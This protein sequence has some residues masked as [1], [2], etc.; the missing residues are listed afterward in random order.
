[1][2]SE[3]RRNLETPGRLIR[4]FELLEQ[5]CL[6]TFQFSD[7][8]VFAKTQLD[9]PFDMVASDFD[10]DGDI[11]VAVTMTVEQRLF[12]FENLGSGDFERTG[13]EIGLQPGLRRP[14]S[15]DIDGDGID[16]LVGTR[17]PY[18]PTA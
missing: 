17:D 2:K 6:L 13:R 3:H 11:D 8:D 14:T 18:A 15:I 10:A 9:F 16:E 7:A 1:M 12:W 4:S 5:R